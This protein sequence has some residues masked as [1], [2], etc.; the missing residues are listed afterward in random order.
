VLGVPA[1]VAPTRCSRFSPATASAT[2]SRWWAARHPIASAGV[3][4]RGGGVAG[5]AG[6]RPRAGLGRGVVAHQRAARQPGVRREEHA[7]FG[8]DR[9]PRARRR[10]AFDPGDDVAAPYVNLGRGPR[11]RSCASRASTATSRPRSRST[12]RVRHLRRPHDRPPGGAVRPRDVTGLV[13]CGGFSYGDTLGAGEGW[14]RSV[15]F[16]EAHR[17]ASTTSSTAGHLRARHLQRLPDVRGAGRPHP[18][19]RRVAAVHPQP[20]EQYEARLSMVEVLDSRRRSSSPAWPGS[21]LPIA[22]AHGEGFAD[23]SQ[24][25]DAD[26]VLRVARFVDSL[27][28]SRRRHT[29][30]TPT[31]RPTG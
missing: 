9:R 23:F 26:A 10:A 30:R 7:A 20:S 17:G 12:G 28:R 14:A 25:G 29:R 5:R 19:R 2:W 21:R 27:V 4:G 1:A 11:S 3:G 6:A 8:A 16:N 13:A 31:G 15:L 22:V 24:R 18:G